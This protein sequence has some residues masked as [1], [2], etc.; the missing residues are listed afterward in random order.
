M[1]ILSFAVVLIALAS[2]AFTFKST[3][4]K[5][6]ISLQQSKIDWAATK[7]TGYHNG[8]IKLKSG[9]VQVENNKLVGGKFTIDVTSLN[10]TDFENPTDNGL[11]KHL[12][13]KDFLE[14]EKYP[15]ATFEITKVDYIN[16][17]DVNITG[18]LTMKAMTLP[19]VFPATINSAD[20]KRFFAYGRFTI[21]RTLWGVNYDVSRASRDVNIGVYILASAPQPAK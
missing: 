19:L 12:M 16:E 1:R 11:V 9:D 15:E 18:N 10:S 7:K 2:L 6:D 4:V 20:D 5:M 14:T 8:I 17:K 3:A 13:S 21:D